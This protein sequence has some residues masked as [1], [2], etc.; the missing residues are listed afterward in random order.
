MQ[1]VREKFVFKDHKNQI[2]FGSDFEILFF[3]GYLGLNIKV[4]KK[5]LAQLDIF[6]PLSRLRGKIVFPPI[7]AQSKFFLQKLNI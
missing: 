5:K 4:L 1:K 3:R 2:F 6:V 7:L